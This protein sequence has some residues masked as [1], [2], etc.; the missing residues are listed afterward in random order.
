M[1]RLLARLICRR[2]ASA[3]HRL[4]QLIGQRLG[5]VG[6]L[7]TALAF[8]RADAAAAWEQAEEWRRIA[9]RRKAL[10][11]G[12]SERLSICS[13]LLSRAAEKQ[14]PAPVL[15]YLDPLDRGAYLTLPP[16]TVAVNAAEFFPGFDV[17]ESA[18]LSALVAD[19]LNGVR[20]SLAN[21]T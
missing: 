4:A 12:L 11:L 18:E 6:A 7:R 20:V 15:R 21:D 5:L 3:T 10:N 17:V 14:R 16:G 13:A 2:V 9:E 19:L 1:V 8:Y